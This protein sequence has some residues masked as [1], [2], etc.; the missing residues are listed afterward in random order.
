MKIYYPSF[1]DIYWMRM[2]RWRLVIEMGKIRPQCVFLIILLSTHHIHTTHPS[3]SSFYVCPS[4]VLYPLPQDNHF[5]ISLMRRNCW[6][7]SLHL[8]NILRLILI[9]Y[10]LSLK[11]NIFCIMKYRVWCGKTIETFQVF[12]WKYKS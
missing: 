8:L 7:I 1:N 2:I 9:A 4:K 12:D 10:I 11:N 5:S 6:R 3:N